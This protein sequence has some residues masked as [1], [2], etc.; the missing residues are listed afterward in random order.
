MEKKVGYWSLQWIPLTAIAYGII[1]AHVQEVS[2][3]DWRDMENS[4]NKEQDESK[5]LGKQNRSK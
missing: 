3:K 4:L 5:H 1:F 2:C